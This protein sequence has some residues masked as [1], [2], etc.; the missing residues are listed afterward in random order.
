MTI[1]VKMPTFTSLVVAFLSCLCVSCRRLFLMTS[2]C[3]T[4]MTLSFWRHNMTSTASRSNA[5][6]QQD[7]NDDCKWR[8][9]SR[10]R[11][12]NDD[13]Q[14]LATSIQRRRARGLTR[15]GGARVTSDDGDDKRRMAG[16]DKAR[17]ATAPRRRQRRRRAGRRQQQQQTSGANRA[18]ARR[19]PL[20][21]VSWSVGRWW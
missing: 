11:L 8:V 19:P 7:R 1:S 2:S 21:F 10:T 20:R 12:D 9:A 18:R 17:V 15:P 16:R 13:R 14:T 4:T 3:H 5:I 6:L